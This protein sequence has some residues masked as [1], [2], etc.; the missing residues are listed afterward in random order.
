MSRTT[1]ILGKP[2]LGTAIA[3]RL[4]AMGK[5]QKWL[6]EEAGISPVYLCTVISGRA[7]PSMKLLCKIANA[8]DI[9]AK[10]LTNAL[11]SEQ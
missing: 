11:L 3:L 5:S 2:P 6:A 10:N 9:D 1:S 4:K 7:M 8:L